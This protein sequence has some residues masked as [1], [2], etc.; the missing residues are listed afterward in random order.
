MGII[1]YFVFQNLNTLF[2]IE[3]SNKI[4]TL[5]KYIRIKFAAPVNAPNNALISPIQFSK[6]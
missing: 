2:I 4:S 5:H 1:S 3:F 6:V